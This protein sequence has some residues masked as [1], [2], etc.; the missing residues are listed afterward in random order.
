MNTKLIE[1]LL[2]EDNDDDVVLIEEAFVEAKIANCLHVVR[3]GQEAIWY[4]RQEGEYKDV[5]RPGLLL[6]DINMPKKNGFEVLKE[7]KAD[8]ALRR[9]PVIMLTTSNR[10]EDIIKSYDEGACTYIRKPVDFD[11]LKDVVKQVAL[12]WGLVATLPS[13]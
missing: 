6:L 4:L 10:D 7:I 3:D 8:T 2:A 11:R 1:I 9:I 13:K 12:Y 5:S